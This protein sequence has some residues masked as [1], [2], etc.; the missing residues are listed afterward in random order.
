[1]LSS[2][3]RPKEHGD[4]IAAALIAAAERTIEEHGIEALSVRGVATEVGTTT[5]AVY[6]VFGSKD[7]LLAALGTHAF[8]LLRDGVEGI[9][10]T[11][12]PRGDLIAAGMM[13]RRF[14]T[15]HPSLFALGVQRQVPSGAWP[16][17]SAAAR[18]ALESLTALI[19]RLEEP[20][21][22]GERTVSE[23]AL[24]FHAL[25]EGLAAVEL[26]RLSPLSD[27]E[28]IWRQGL[29]ALV[30]GFALS[31]EQTSE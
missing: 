2:V 11:D 7:G 14:A 4:E 21:L 19:A 9:P 5:R 20:Q 18:T 31:G 8:N 12:D 30:G 28:R 16:D 26:R 17:V 13:F 23:A 27:S 15:E 1:M 3:G 22:L 29:T 25:C 6:S 10:R 24:E